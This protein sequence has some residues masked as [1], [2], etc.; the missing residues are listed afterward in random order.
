QLT[1]P[2][3][4]E[5]MR[6]RGLGGKKLSV[7]W[8][9]AKIDTVAALLEAC[10]KN[11]LS[12][13]PGFGLKTQQNIIAAIESDRSNRDRFHYASVADDAIALVDLLQKIFKTKLISL[14][15]EVR[16]QTTTTASI[17]IIAAI[18]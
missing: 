16:R 2:G 10:K 9:V 4:F 5:M 17:E 7:L 14:C 6:I 15:G 8:R 12:Q 13:I 1:P 3:L 18:D 11:G